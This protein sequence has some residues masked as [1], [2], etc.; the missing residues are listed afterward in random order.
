MT[1]LAVDDLSRSFGGIHAVDGVT[2]DVE[3]A[4]IVG[5]IGPN[6]SGKSTLFNLLT[7]ALKPD[8]GTITL[9]DREHHPARRLPDSPCRP[10]AAPSRSRRCS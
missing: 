1:V 6:G 5:I 9:F 8:A 10:R 2:F 7:G 3:Q 4:E